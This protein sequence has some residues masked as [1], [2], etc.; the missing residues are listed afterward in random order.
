MILTPSFPMR[1]GEVLK[2]SVCA[3][4]Q[5]LNLT[6]GVFKDGP[7]YRG[8]F[9]VADCHVDEVGDDS[10]LRAEMDKRLAV[11]VADFEKQ[12][13]S[14]LPEI[15]EVIRQLEHPGGGPSGRPSVN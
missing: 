12:F 7:G 11:S 10:Q 6:V 8:V 3:N 15:N 1:D 9:I 5:K 14:A 2:W 4:C 13:G